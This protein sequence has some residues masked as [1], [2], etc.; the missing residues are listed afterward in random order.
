[1]HTA[2]AVA[3]VCLLIALAPCLKAL[4]RGAM[5]VAR[6]QSPTATLAGT[7][8][9]EA[10]AVV[11]S[12]SITMLNLST[13]LQRHATTSD[14]GFYVIPLLP[15][16]RYTL[17]AQRDGFST[18][19]VRNIVLNV[20]DQLALR[21]KLKVGEIG[22]AVTIIEDG[23][24]GVQQAS[25][26]ST[27][28]DRQF[29]ENLPLNGR[30]F[31]SL[32]ELAPGTVLTKSNFSEQGQFSVNG[33]R[34]NA[35]YFMV[36]GVS[37]NIGVSAGAAPGQAAGG[38]LPAVTTLGGLNN[39][40]SAD[41]LE[42]FRV[43]TSSYAPEFGRTPGAQ[44][45]ILTR[46]G[47]D[48]FHGTAF[49]YFRNDALDA[50]DFFANSRALPRA[51]LRQNDFG[52]TVGGPFIRNRAFFFFSYEG[53][54]LRQPQV[55]LTEVPTLAARSLAP[56]PLR[57][58]LRAFPIPNGVE[59]GDG[60]AEFTASYS[61]PSSLDAASLRFDAIVGART[62]VFA[63]FNHAPSKTAQRGGVT[64]PGFGRQSLNT[65]NRTS[66]DT[67]TLTFGATTALAAATVNDLRINWS[68]ARGA[69]VLSTDDFGGAEPPPDSLLF[70]P[71]ASPRT[72]GFRFTLSGGANSNFGVGEIVDNRQRQLNVVDNLSVTSGANSL[73]FGIDLRRLTPTYSP[74]G[75]EQSVLF[76]D[77]NLS[78][79][80]A[81][82]ANR[83]AFQVQVSAESEPREPLFTNFSAYAQNTWRATP[84]LTFTYGVRW[85]LN[86]PPH[87]RNGNEPVAVTGFDLED[88]D[89]TPGPPLGSPIRILAL[90]PRGTPLWKTTY[91]NFA[92]RVGLA[93]QPWERRALV[94]RGGLGVFY[95]LGNG[96]AGQ[97]FGSVFPF[98]RE[99]L[100]SNVPFPLA[101]GQAAPPEL[102]L[103]PP[104][105]LI[106]TFD[107][108]LKLPY[109]L[110]WNL[111]VEHAVGAKQTVSAAY[112]A[113]V[114]RRL[115]REA[116]LFS[117]GGGFTVVRVV[118][119][120]SHSDYH[121]LQV[122]FQRRLARG[123]QAQVNYALAHSID[124][125]S[126]DSSTTL[127]RGI[128]SRQERGNSTFD[129]RH[130]ITAAA[131]YE[132]PRAFAGQ[133][134]IGDRLFRD[135]AVDTIVRARTATPVNIFFGTGIVIGD[136]VEIRR[137]DLVP[138]VPLYVRDS[139]LAG[140]RRINPG[141]FFLPAGR[142]GTLGRNALRGFGFW[143]A[144][145]AVRRRLK[146]GE[147]LELQLRAE[148]FNLFN[149]P[150]FG[151][152]VGDLNNRLFGQATQM[153]ARSLGTGGVN[154]GLS[155][156]YQIGGPRS[157]QLAVKLQF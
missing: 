156:L 136:L 51:A 25:G 120:T 19:E 77:G 66:L 38:S 91:T 56:A 108:N 87:E 143:Q 89:G 110:Q 151:D 83:N 105:G 37:A 62:T 10:G 98:R 60:F 121:S 92:P 44:V 33:Q 34:A 9:D 80:N 15:P 149:H 31:Q 11:P 99:K 134:T 53:L 140:G 100:L 82:L 118:T 152:P 59:T 64:V 146:L 6:A 135:W 69:T 52:G 96:Q 86:P 28:V 71:F 17:T 63:R 23:G 42:E 131:T 21:I 133:G 150:S 138:G 12:V 4:A 94:L 76:G 113:A 50:N 95:D 81:I 39:L 65:L 35:N 74:L 78:G 32:L 8:S 144:D 122:Q 73:K 14:E 67:D 43:L 72:A 90:A 13:A 2:L 132:L 61:D 139:T 103:N 58:F 79:V 106:Y 124:D 126:D 16:G 41:A 18:V 128:N 22:E 155:P 84:R 5:F 127:V 45:S 154:G 115:L 29:V 142:Q 129:V 55:A 109:T 75:Y 1:M 85:E 57:P 93:F 70:P 137:P 112:V 46:S 114:G 24:G 125:D 97:A 40:V 101:P 49:N 107:P 3:G 148:V 145:V 119:N 147:A 7:V 88:A 123:L 27:I 104:F 111:S 117:P 116:A 26:V 153:L 54:R 157:I 141:A 102:N 48:E 68:R 20:N 30:S 36:D 47:T 130:S